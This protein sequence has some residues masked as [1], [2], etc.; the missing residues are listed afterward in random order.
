[1]FG[2]STYEFCYMKST[3]I[4]KGHKIRRGAKQKKEQWETGN[5]NQFTQIRYRSF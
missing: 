2:V 5:F 4:W 3:D 1:M